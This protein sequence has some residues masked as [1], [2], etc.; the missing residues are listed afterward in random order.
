LGVEKLLFEKE[1]SMN[2]LEP[3]EIE[4]PRE[5]RIARPGGM[6]DDAG[7]YTETETTV[8][9]HMAADIQLSEKIRKLA[10]E[11][12]TGISDTALWIMYCVPDAAIETGD[13]V[14]DG[15]RVFRVEAAGDWGSHMECVM[16]EV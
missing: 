6:Y 15:E 3:E 5:V 16:K 11:D 4:Y 14:Y 7:N 10:S 9:E 8:I 12:G 13:R 2:L 1:T